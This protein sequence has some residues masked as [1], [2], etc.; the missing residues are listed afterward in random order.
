MACA[1][2]VLVR[3]GAIA[4]YALMELTFVRKD[5]RPSTGSVRSDFPQPLGR[6]RSAAVMCQA[7]PT[8]HSPTAGTRSTCPA[9]IARGYDRG[10]ASSA[11]EERRQLL[12]PVELIVRRSTAPLR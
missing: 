6:S 12:L 10:G 9:R 11:G 5:R 1:C 2:E 8:S 4:V 7:A 3:H